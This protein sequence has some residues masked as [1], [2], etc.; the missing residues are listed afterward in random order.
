MAP[1]QIRGGTPGPAGDIYALGVIFYEMVTGRRPHAGGTVPDL[2]AAVLRDRPRPPSALAPDCP[3][4]LSRLIERCLAPDPRERFPSAR[5]L[6]DELRELA[7][8]YE[9]GARDPVQSIA[10]LPLSD[11]SLT[12][13]QRHLCDGIAEE[14]IAALTRIDGLAVA[15]RMSSFRYRDTGGDSREIARELGVRYLLEGSVRRDDNR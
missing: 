3:A 11:L 10:V 9:T 2:F 13:D 8:R 6:R 14:V 5:G 4:P 7:A 15:S 12:G 1:E